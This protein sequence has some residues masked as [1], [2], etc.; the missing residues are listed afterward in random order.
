[1]KLLVA[2]IVGLLVGSTIGW[3]LG[4]SRTASR[5]SHEA[6][7]YALRLL[8]PQTAAAA[9]YAI[10]AIPMIDRGD[11]NAAIERLSRMIAVYYHNYASQPGTNVYRIRAKAVIDE[12]S[13]TNQFVARMLKSDSSR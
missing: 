6:E 9:E 1:M 4:A 2:L 7:E 10:T 5:M 12:M 11:T 8:E 3:A 13:Q